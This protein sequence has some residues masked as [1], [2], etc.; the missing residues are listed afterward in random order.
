LCETRGV[1]DYAEKQQEEFLMATDL[2]EHFS[3]LEDPRMERN[4]AHELIDIIVLTICALASG[5]EGWEAIEDFGKEKLEWL[6]HYVALKNGVPSHDCI[7]Y[8]LRR[9]SPKKFRE[10]FMSWTQSVSDQTDG[11]VIAIDG[12]TAKGSRDRKNNRHP[13]HMVSA[14]ACHNRLV[15]GQEATEEK[16]NEI[17]AIPKLLE[18]LELK[19]C[20]VTLDAM[21]CQRAIAEQ[22]IDQEGDYVLGL[23][24]NQG[25]LHEAVEDFF[26]VALANQFAGI[27]HEYEEEVDKDHGRFEIRRYWITDDLR[28]LPDTENWKGLRSIGLVERECQQGDQFTVERRYFINSITPQAKPFARAVRGHWGIEN[29]LH[30]R[31]DV[32]FGDDASRIRKDN[33]PAIMTSIRHLCMNLFERESSS[34]SLAKKRRK[35]A[36][37]DDYRAKVIFS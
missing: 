36:W 8:V 4:K 16:S 27:A 33:G 1:G 31:L 15:L 14:W 12:K 17:T 2:I 22:I 23:K 24:G 28:T 3:L 29:P 30:W 21:G 13:L 9:L 25:E 32:V 34:L 18:L 19:G 10:C 5:A 7:A 20:I 35:A 26:T 6:R 11:E 37:N